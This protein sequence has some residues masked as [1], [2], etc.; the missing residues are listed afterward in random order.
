MDFS[1]VAPY[2]F[3]GLCLFN[4]VDQCTSNKL[5]CINFQLNLNN[6]QNKRLSYACDFS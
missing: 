4:N 6:F 1:A 2:G 3:I 5:V